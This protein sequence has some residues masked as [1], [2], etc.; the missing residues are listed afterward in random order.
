LHEFSNDA[1]LKQPGL[2]HLDADIYRT[3]KDR[4]DAARRA[5]KIFSNTFTAID[6]MQIVI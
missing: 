2:F 1:G 5:G 4:E 6:D 3:L